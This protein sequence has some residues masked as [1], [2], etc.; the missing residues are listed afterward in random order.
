MTI[1]K[2]ML[3]L[4]E[5]NVRTKSKW[6]DES[7]EFFKC[8]MCGLVVLGIPDRHLM[9]INAHRLDKVSQYNLP[10]KLD[11]PRCKGAW[12]KPGQINSY[13]VDDVTVDELK[14]SDWRWILLDV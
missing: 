12:Y 3:N 6:Q 4:S 2:A 1:D 5:F 10:R 9:L 14:N 7:L 8:R 11:C 13:Q